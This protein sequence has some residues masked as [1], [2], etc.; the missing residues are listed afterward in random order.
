MWDIDVIG[1]CRAK[2]LFN[3]MHPRC[4]DLRRVEWSEECDLEDLSKLINRT[5]T[6]EPPDVIV[7]IGGIYDVLDLRN[8]PETINLQNLNLEYAS[9][10]LRD[11]FEA[12]IESA[13]T[14]NKD[15][16]IVTSMLY[17]ADLDKMLRKQSTHPL[18]SIMNSTIIECN[19]FLID[20]NIKSSASTPYLERLC[21]NYKPNKGYRHDYSNLDDGCHP[22]EA[23]LE[24]TAGLIIKC[25]EKMSKK[26][27]EG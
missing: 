5:V 9:K 3:I 14:I 8:F 4:E 16:K 11:K 6:E 20:L 24:R 10:T 1:D 2:G 12:V 17:G 18:Q 25:L 15:V 26:V 22:N 13:N 23:T 21:H 19:K 7:V 27:D